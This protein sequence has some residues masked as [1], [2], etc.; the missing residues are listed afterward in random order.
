MN[1]SLSV[2]G[3]QG[4]EYVFATFGTDHPTLIKG[5]ASENAPTPILAPYEMTAASAAHG[6]AQVTG[7]PGVVLVHV[8]R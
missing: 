3:E 5:L 1:G 8:D 6:Y 2:S 4:I 7:N